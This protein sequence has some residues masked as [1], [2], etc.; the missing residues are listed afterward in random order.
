MLASALEGFLH[1]F[2]NLQPGQF[3]LNF[4]RRRRASQAPGNI[5][6]VT[7]RRRLMTFADT[8]VEFRNF[9]AT[10]GAQEIGEMTFRLAGERPDKFALRVEEGSIGNDSFRAG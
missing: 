10:H 2:V 5:P 8:R 6:D 4:F 7:E 1:I 3:L 9:A